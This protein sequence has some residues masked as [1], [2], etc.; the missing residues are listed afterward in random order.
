MKDG[1]YFNEC[2]AEV[3]VQD[4]VYH[5]VDGPAII[6]KYGSKYWYRNGML[7]RDDGPTVEDIDGSQFWYQNGNIHREDGPAAIYDEDSKDYWLEGIHYPKIKNDIQWRL[8]VQRIKRKKK[9][10]K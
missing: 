8:E 5:R 3:Y 10:A 7:H 2:N 4:G 6:Y 1:H 9:E